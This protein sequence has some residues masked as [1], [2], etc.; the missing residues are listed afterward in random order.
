[1]NQ[2]LKKLLKLQEIDA[3]LISLKQ[4][5]EEI[6]GQ[7]RSDQRDY[8]SSV[9]KLHKHRQHRKELEVE[10]MELQLDIESTQERIG[11]LKQ[12]Q[13][14]VKKNVE[15]QAL[16]NE[17][18]QAQQSMTRH[19]AALEKKDAAIQDYKDRLD[20]QADAVKEE[21]DT[22]LKK[23]EEAKKPLKEIQ[24][25]MHRYYKIRQQLA[26]E[27]RP[28]VLE[29]YN[30]L[31]KTRAPVAVVPANNNVCAGCHINLPPQ[32]VGDIMKADRLVICENCARILYIS[33]EEEPQ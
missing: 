17:I 1:M 25:K 20:H 6:P 9:N 18:S 11:K 14:Q 15:Y 29:L 5:L 27:V 7:L 16:T 30:R 33:D 13:A 12:K 2:Q 23:A 22:L 4:Q 8:E 3:D 28:D 19:T 10:R 26:Q 21:K 24:D 32:V 31:M